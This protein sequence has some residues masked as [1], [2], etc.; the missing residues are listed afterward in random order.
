MNYSRRPGIDSDGRS[1]STQSIYVTQ[2]S[3]LGSGPDS[4]PMLE[5]PRIPTRIR[6]EQM[7]S[8]L[9]HGQRNKEERQQKGHGDKTDR[10]VTDSETGKAAA[11]RFPQQNS[12]SRQY[13]VCPFEKYDPARYESCRGRRL[14]RISDITYH[15]S[16][17][18]VLR[19]VQVLRDGGPS[20]MTTTSTENICAY[21]S[22]CRHEFR[23]QDARER[24]YDHTLICQASNQPATIE[25]TGVLLPREFEELKSEVSSVSGIDAKWNVIWIKCF[26]ATSPP[27]PY[28][29]NVSNIVSQPK[30]QKILQQLLS[31]SAA[32]PW[33]SSEIKQSRIEKALGAIYFGLPFTEIEPQMNDASTITTDYIS[34]VRSYGESNDDPNDGSSTVPESYDDLGDMDQWTRPL[35][36]A[37]YDVDHD[38]VHDILRNSFDKVAVG[39]Y[40]WLL[41]LKELGI[42]TDDIADELLERAQHGPWIYSKIDVH[43]V[44]S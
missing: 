7:R 11:L 4:R 28:A 44:G 32:N 24:L 31:S 40:S 22:R 36:V 23:V 29:S 38:T 39:E 18:H 13:M 20:L 41:E 17:V 15:I 8:P 12:P 30:A 1:K 9:E 3:G 42:S 33:S 5:S 19:G 25:Q 27:P 10:D 26:P 16:R 21:C 2:V 35:R 43:D 6:G 34:T 37:I 14:R